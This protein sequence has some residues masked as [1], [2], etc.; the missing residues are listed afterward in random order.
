M[1]CLILV[2][3]TLFAFL[4]I[5]KDVWS[6]SERRR[7]DISQS[8]RIKE[9]TRKCAPVAKSL[10]SATTEVLFIQTG[11][12]I[13]KGY[14]RMKLGYAFEIGDPAVEFI[15]DNVN[16]LIRPTITSACKKDST[17]LTDLDRK[18]ILRLCTKSNHD[19][20][21]I[22]H[23]TDTMIETGKYLQKN[24]SGKTIVLTGSMRPEKFKDSDAPF[25]VGFAIGCL[26]CVP[27]GVYI[28]M[29]A[30]CTLADQIVRGDDGFFHRK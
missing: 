18:D 14:P 1:S 27:E 25:N 30:Q 29:N 13:D 11:G 23:G 24:L 28:C 22:T 26:Q 10:P 17:E 4:T 3:G 20:I 7:I 16:H 6:N 19:R 9:N 21:L 2:I 5:C 8:A 12:T 15:L